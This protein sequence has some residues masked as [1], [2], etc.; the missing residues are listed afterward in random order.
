MIFYF[1]F[2]NHPIANNKIEKIIILLYS[3]TLSEA[4][5]INTLIQPYDLPNYPSFEDGK[6]EWVSEG[7]FQRPYSFGASASVGS[8]LLVALIAMYR[9][10][11]WK[12]GL[13]ILSVL[14][15][16]SEVGI[17]LLVAILFFCLQ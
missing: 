11:G 8:S 14:V 5:L 6:T 13:S 15:F 10:R 4:L 9:L 3:F 2:K 17:L 16:G 7:L 12:F 1:I